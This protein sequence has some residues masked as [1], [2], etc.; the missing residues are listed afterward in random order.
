MIPRAPRTVQRMLA[1]APGGAEDDA[2]DAR[3]GTWGAEDDATAAC[4]GTQGI[5]DDFSLTG[6]EVMT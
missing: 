5:K 2:K 1:G 6:V 4:F 3:R